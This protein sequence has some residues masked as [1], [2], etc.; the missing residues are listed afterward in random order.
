MTA[1]RAAM[2]L[3]GFTAG[4]ATGAGLVLIA[5]SRLERGYKNGGRR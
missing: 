5:L 3:G 1:R 2:V 4:V